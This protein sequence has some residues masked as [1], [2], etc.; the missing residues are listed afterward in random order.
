MSQEKP[1][2]EEELARE[3]AQV[4]AAQPSPE[5]VSAQPSVADL[6]K[7]RIRRTMILWLVLVFAFTLIYFLLHPGR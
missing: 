7:K 2:S 5:A 3:L 1:P 4:R 6:L